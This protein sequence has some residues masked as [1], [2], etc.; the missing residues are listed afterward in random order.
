[1][2]E[3]IDDLETEG[4]GGENR[5]LSEVM[6][7][8]SKKE[9]FPELVSITVRLKRLFREVYVLR[10]LFIERVDVDESPSLNYQAFQR[11]MV[12]ALGLEK[13]QVVSQQNVTTVRSS[14]GHLQLEELLK[15][16]FNFGDANLEELTPFTQFL[17]RDKMKSGASKTEIFKTVMEYAY[18]NRIIKH[19]VW[20][21]QQ[22]GVILNAYKLNDWCAQIT[23]ICNSLLHTFERLAKDE[24]LLFPH[25]DKDLVEVIYAATKLQVLIQQGGGDHLDT[26]YLSG[27]TEQE[28]DV[29]EDHLSSYLEAGWRQKGVQP[30]GLIRVYKPGDPIVGKTVK[31]IL[32]KVGSHIIAGDNIME[33]NDGSFI[34]LRIEELAPQHR[35]Q[36]CWTITHLY[37]REGQE[38]GEMQ[39]LFKMTAFNVKVV[40]HTFFEL[41]FDT[42]RQLGKIRSKSLLIKETIEEELKR[43]SLTPTPSATEDTGYAF[44]RDRFAGLS[45][46]EQEEQAEQVT[47]RTGISKSKARNVVRKVSRVLDRGPRRA[48][49]TSSED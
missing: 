26:D 42:W 7:Y 1:M 8:M 32:A 24:I 37:A 13:S 2:T 49:K 29:S 11:E 25:L 3:E 19:R 20:G 39:P 14:S 18:L 6:R 10:A 47:Q 17:I 12:S 30:K 46:K 16:E 40:E 28:K 43:G 34:T 9:F 23:D 4:S 5:V 36:P 48:Q 27:E 41:L 21:F 22:K 44:R 38:I 35:R 33:L 45:I 31:K 15:G